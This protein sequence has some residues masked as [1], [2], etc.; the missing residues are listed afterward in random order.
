MSRTES[1][2]ELVAEGVLSAEDAYGMDV[3]YRYAEEKYS[4]KPLLVSFMDMVKGYHFVQG[5]TDSLDKMLDSARR[6]APVV[7]PLMAGITMIESM[8]IEFQEAI[9]EIK[10]DQIKILRMIDILCDDKKKAKES[11]EA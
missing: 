5:A 10:R 9:E 3:F 11:S 2:K 7:S 4:G 6:N 1:T 8:F